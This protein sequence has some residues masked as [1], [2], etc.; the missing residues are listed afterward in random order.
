MNQWNWCIATSLIKIA[1]ELKFIIPYFLIL[2]L[3][4]I[5]SISHPQSPHSLSTS[6]RWPCLL[7]SSDTTN[8][9]FTIRSISNLASTW[10]YPTLICRISAVFLIYKWLKIDLDDC[11]NHCK[12][13]Y[14]KSTNDVDQVWTTH[15]LVCDGT[16]RKW[17]QM[18]LYHLLLIQMTC[19]YWSNRIDEGLTWYRAD[20]QR[21]YYLFY[22]RGINI[23]INIKLVK[24]VKFKYQS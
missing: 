14:K 24:I 23:E 5:I 12:L 9:W 8:L 17:T 4:P 6:L 19:F 20:T 1:K 21:H 2:P 13:C 15:G 7:P 22:N 11:R 3:L 18:L 16:V 10:K